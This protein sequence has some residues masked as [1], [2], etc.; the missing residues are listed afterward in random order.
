MVYKSLKRNK[1]ILILIYNIV[2]KKFILLGF[3]WNEI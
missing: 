2:L 1:S 3:G